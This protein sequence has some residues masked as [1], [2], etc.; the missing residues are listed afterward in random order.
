MRAA[1]GSFLSVFLTLIKSEM[2]ELLDWPFTK[3]VRVTLMD[4]S[5]DM[6]SRRHVSHVIDPNYELDDC[7]QSRLS[8]ASSVVSPSSENRSQFGVPQ[9]IHLEQ[10]NAPDKYIRDDVVYFGVSVDD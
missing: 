1:Q 3:R 4:Q 5:D 8:V 6:E 7:M 10:L 9:F 2:D